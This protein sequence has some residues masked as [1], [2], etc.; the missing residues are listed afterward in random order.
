MTQS[1]SAS[2]SSRRSRPPRSRMSTSTPFSSVNAAQP[3]VELVDLVPLLAE[4]RRQ[5]ADHRHPLRVVGHGDV[6][7]PSLLGRLGH[8]LDRGHAVGPGA[9]GV[10]VAADVAQLDQLGELAGRGPLELAAGLAQLGREP[11]QVQ[12]RVDFLLR[13][14]RRSVARRGRRR[15]R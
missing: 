4:L 8:L 11:G 14:R 13:L 15:T 6:L 5:A 3:R 9:V 2:T 7:Q 10:Q 1:A 12:R